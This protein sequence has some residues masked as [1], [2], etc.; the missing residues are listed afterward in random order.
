MAKKNRKERKLVDEVEPFEPQAGPT[1]SGLGDPQVEAAAS[2]PDPQDAESSEQSRAAV[3]PSAEQPDSPPE[4]EALE[5]PASDATS[6]TEEK[7][8][9]DDLLAD[10]RRSLVEE[11]QEQEEK[12]SWWRKLA[13]GRRKE[14][15]R[16]PE[17][18]VPEEEI[19]LPADQGPV[20][21][22][23][24]QEETEESEE[25]LDQIDELIGMLEPTSEE[26]TPEAKVDEEAPAPPEPVEPVHKVDLE[27][28]KKQAFRPSAPGEEPES[29]SDVRAI[30]LEGD[31]EVFVE[32]ESKAQDPMQERLKAFENAV[33]PYRQYINIAFAFL[34]V[35][36]ALIAGLLLY[37]FYQQIQPEETPVVESNLPYPT[38]VSLPG[39]WSF[40]LGRGTLQ[41]GR[42]NPQGAEWLEGTEVCRWV[43]LPWS[44]QLEAVIRTLN[45]DDPIELVMSNND[46][47]IY[48]VYSVRQLSSEEM[49]DLDTRTPCLLV[50]LAEADSD[51][52]WVLTALP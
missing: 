51:S 31:E 12:S 2:G 10:V 47:L 38:S 6:S 35:V 28:L 39:G 44:R 22:I 42:W 1:E 3:E 5:T 37:N 34:G 43:A 45:P 24:E 52:R 16:Q 49:L 14:K 33:K 7:F 29:F 30:A 11:S 32:V 40:N 41:D 23:K 18:A 46:R 50:V 27:E 48:K 36:M 25:Y 13:G 4:P 26:E 20:E 19:Q 9:E 15:T 21:E 17:I 8:S